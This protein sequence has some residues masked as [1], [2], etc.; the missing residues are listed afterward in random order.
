MDPGWREQLRET[1]IG[2]DIWKTAEELVKEKSN[3][4]TRLE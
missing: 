1:W 4:V 3:V 2:R